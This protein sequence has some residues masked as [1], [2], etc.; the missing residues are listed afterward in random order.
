MHRRDKTTDI[1]TEHLAQ[2]FIDLRSPRLAPQPVAKLRLYHHEGGFNITS[3]VVLL[4]ESL[5]VV[6]EVVIHLSPEGGL[7]VALRVDGAVG[8]ES[9]V[10][11]RMSINYGLHVLC[12]AINKAQSSGLA[13]NVRKSSDLWGN[14][15]VC[16]ITLSEW[17]SAAICKEKA[18][19]L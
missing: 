18:A 11:H 12:A 8:L 1:V 4:H 3:L 10:R 16:S 6:R 17:L 19:K 2:R 14:R 13:R 15:V 7:V 9:D 5:G